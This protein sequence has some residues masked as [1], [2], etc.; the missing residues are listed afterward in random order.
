MSKNNGLSLVEELQSITDDL[1]LSIVDSDATILELKK[2][3]T[4]STTRTSRRTNSSSNGKLNQATADQVVE[5]MIEYKALVEDS[6]K[7]HPKTTMQ[8]KRGMADFLTF[9]WQLSG[10]KGEFKSYPNSILIPA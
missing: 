5:S 6:L 7:G 2:L 1:R 9:I 10:R 8:E 4:K 3:S